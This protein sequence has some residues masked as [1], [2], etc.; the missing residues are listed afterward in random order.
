MRSYPL[1]VFVSLLLFGLFVSNAPATSAQGISQLQQ[2]TST[3]SPS[4]AITQTTFG[5]AL[6]ITG[7]TTGQCLT[8]NSGSILTAS[9]CPSLVLP[10]YAS[11]TIG[12]TTQAGGLTINGGATTTGNAYFGSK[13]GIG[14]TTPAQALSVAGNGLVSGTLYFADTGGTAGGSIRWTAAT[15]K[16]EMF[17]GS[18]GFEINNSVGNVK[19]YRNGTSASSIFNVSSTGL[20]SASGIQNAALIDPTMTQTGT[21]G[22]NGLFI[23]ITESTTGSGAKNLIL[24]RANGADRF[25]VNSAGYVGIGTT[26]PRGMLDIVDNGTIAS[27]GTTAVMTVH[28]ASA[29]PYLGAFFNDAYSKTVPLLQYFGWTSVSGNVPGIV[30]GD[31]E[32]GNSNPR[33][34]VFYTN[35]YASPRMSITGTGLVGIGTTSPTESLLTVATPIGATGSTLNLFRIASSTGSAT[36]TLFNVNNQG[37]VAINTSVGSTANVSGLA[38]NGGGTL[39]QVFSSGITL[40]RSGTSNPGQLYIQGSTNV[41]GYTTQHGAGLNISTTLYGSGGGTGKWSALL[42]NPTLA[43]GTNAGGGTYLMSAFEGT[44]AS[45]SR[46]FY[47]T[48]G[49]AGNNTGVGSTTPFAKLSVHAQNGD[50]NPWLFSIGSSTAAT[51]STLFHITNDGAVV[52]D[53]AAAQAGQAMCY[54]TGGVFGHCT[55]TVD[56][57]GACTCVAN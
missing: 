41:A 55:S 5:K 40:S 35:G 18:T 48:A 8:L 10:Y 32:M 57:G 54:A 22:Y 33:K 53:S 17:G 34:L 30:G 39:F 42:V 56:A 26:S 37:D 9:S 19:I 23:N 11:T 36:T 46:G 3:T 51:T 47:V 31:F 24:A 45:T 50:L 27:D 1:T 2:F 15:G 29:S 25:V 6:K 4:S 21:A 28:A 14:T 16:L 38:V 43:V 49:A 12:D 44:T 7:L 20:A 13:V 52:Q